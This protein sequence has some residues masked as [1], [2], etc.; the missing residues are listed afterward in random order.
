MTST[1]C[2]WQRSVILFFV[3]A[4]FT[5]VLKFLQVQRSTPVAIFPH[6]LL[7]SLYSGWWV[8]P[9]C[10][11]ASALVGLLYP[12]VDEKLGEPH[13]FRREWSSVMRCATVFVGISHATAKIDF[14]SNTQLSLAL[15]AMSIGLWWFFDRS[16]NGLGLGVGIAI[17][18]T[19]I[20]QILLY[21]QVFNY[22]ESDFLYVRSWLP[23]VFFSGGVTV[24]SI[25]RQLALDD[26][27]SGM[28]SH[29]M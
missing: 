1:V 18:A 29:R 5:L 8:T 11:S 6:E 23:S 14:D 27:I 7:A 10:G 22:T 2:I 21:Q 20:Y 13:T 26:Q 28:K 9:V 4:F 25:G 3:G 15:A 24:G 16:I 19:F 12:C 17:L